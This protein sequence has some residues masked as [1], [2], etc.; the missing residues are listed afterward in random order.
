MQ[1]F[2]MKISSILFRFAYIYTNMAHID[3]QSTNSEDV[4]NINVFI[5]INKTKTNKNIF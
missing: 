4:H 5:I 1:F 3:M 2:S